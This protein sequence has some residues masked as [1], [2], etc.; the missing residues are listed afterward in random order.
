MCAKIKLDSSSCKK[1]RKILKSSRNLSKI[2][3]YRKREHYTDHN[4][5]HFSFLRSN[6]QNPVRKNYRASEYETTDFLTEVDD[7]SKKKKKKKTTVLVIS[8]VFIAD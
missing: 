1:H 4:S 8:H 3:H 7:S 6:V 2:Y 5:K